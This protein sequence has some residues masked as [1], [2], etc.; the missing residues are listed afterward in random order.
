MSSLK[1]TF[2]LTSLIFLI[3]LGLVFVPTAVMAHPNVTGGTDH[4]K[5]GHM[6]P[7]V[8]VMVDDADPDTEG[9]QVVRK[10]TREADNTASP[11]ITAITDLQIIFDVKL[12]LDPD[13]PNLVDEAGTAI[14]ATSFEAASITLG[15]L[16][17][18]KDGAVPGTSAAVGADY[19]GEELEWTT[20]VTITLTDDGD[21]DTTD[22]EQREAAIAG[23][24]NLDLTAAA[25]LI[26]A[27]V[28]RGP[29]SDDVTDSTNPTPY[30]N[31]ASETVMI[32]IIDAVPM[33]PPT[34]TITAEDATVDAP[35][36]A[37]LTFEP[38]VTELTASQIEVTGGVAGTP[39]VDKSDSKVWTVEITPT[40]NAE[41]VTVSVAEGVA[42]VTGD[43]LEVTD[44]TDTTAPTVAITMGNQDGRTLP[45][46]ITAT[47]NDA[48]ASGAMIEGSEITVTGGTKPTI[49]A[50]NPLTFDVTINYDTTEVTVAVAADA[51]ADM[52]GNMSAAASETF[53]VTA[54]PE[55]VGGNPTRSENILANL[56]IPA[57]SY[58][59]IARTGA[60]GLPSGFTPVI[61][62]EMPDL[63]DLLFSG[64]TI[65]V[66]RAKAPQVDHDNDDPDGNGKKAD[67]TTDASAK[68]DIGTRD[69]VITEVMAALNTAKET[70]SDARKAH[71]WIEVHNKLKVKVTGITVSTKAGHPAGFPE[72]APTDQVLLDRLSNVDGVG[73]QFTGL[74]ENG[75]DDG[76][77]ENTA[78]EVPFA[79]FYRN[80]T[81]EPGWQKARWTTS[82]EVYRTNHKG[83]PGTKERS[84]VPVLATDELN[85]KPAI[86]NE[87][88]NFPTATKAYEW[89]EIRVT[90]G[91]HRF[92][93]WRLEAIT[94]TSE[95]NVTPIVTLPEIPDAQKIGVDGI[96]LVTNTDP[97]EDDDHPLAVGYNVMKDANNQARGVPANH[98]VRYLVKAF[99]SELPSGDF[100]LALRTR[101]DRKNH[102]GIVDLAGYH[103]NLKVDRKDF[104]TNLWPPAQF[105]CPCL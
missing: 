26:E 92:K 7:T 74:G 8:T 5:D 33:P 23:G 27:Q 52:A 6:H 20:E 3:A 43:D 21:T 78:A 98:P 103:G 44:T 91:N 102:E 54:V 49:T 1:M 60:E 34:V 31:L 70:G 68:R 77:G 96:L 66:T 67:G 38:A 56:S 48:L 51:V 83:T 22:A 101:N 12:M 42:E 4:A 65:N 97:A 50:A 90:E 30:H 73:W 28:I 85:Q 84:A 40:I 24:I 105:W 14:A 82:T 100:V 88:G 69:I 59:V 9:I 79:S 45:I 47:D 17:N 80:H 89:I 25:G 58:I 37:T 46:T 55:P 62:D 64:G 99:E 81:G 95:A 76:P 94:G 57:E 16:Y 32:R 39:M 72:G 104:F 53:T 18:D 87:V 35:F 36:T 19:T 29:Y 71:Q 75:S 2:S 41:A 10:A 11:P 13:A 61:W 86:I 15:T 93:N 63:D